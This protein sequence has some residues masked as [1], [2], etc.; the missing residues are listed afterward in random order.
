MERFFK[1][2]VLD[3]P[4][5]ESPPQHRVRAKLNQ[6]ESPFDIPEEVKQRVLTQA[7]DLAFNRYPVNESPNI[8]Q[9]LAALYGVSTDHILLGNGSN[10]LLQT[11]LTA[12]LEPNDRVLYCPPT[13][14]LFDLFVPI[15]GGRPV[16][17]MWGPGLEFPLEKVLE[18]IRRT[19]PKLILLCSPNNPTGAQIPLSDL[20][21][22][23]RATDGLVLWDE[24]YGEFTPQ[25]AIPR[26]EKWPQ[27][28]VSR[29]F[30][31]AFSLAGLRFGYLVANPPVIEQLRKVNLP[32]NVNLFTERV[33]AALLDDVSFVRNQVQ[34]LIE[35]RD[36]LFSA[37]VGL[38][39]VQVYPSGANFLL[40]RTEDGRHIFQ[41]LKEH[42][43][44]VRDVSSYPLLKNHL[45]VNAGTREENDL[46]LQALAE[47]L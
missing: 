8:R 12:A 40:F 3:L 47:S 42:G 5:Y 46:F 27:L 20:E 45:R 28:I 19:R 36:R 34:F 35:E 10:Q 2:V 1:K 31:K 23:L 33:V 6:N 37:M 22:V 26:L 21:H 39:R 16:E 30:S 32:Y 4:G 13:F 11:V 17:V 44:L 29:T 24:A 14:S 9:K 7:A 41:S 18:E 15:Y 38:D 25:S 43:V